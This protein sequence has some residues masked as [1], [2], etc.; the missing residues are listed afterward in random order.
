LIVAVAAPVF[1]GANAPRTAAVRS[2]SVRGGATKKKGHI[3]HVEPIVREAEAKRLLITC[4]TQIKT[5]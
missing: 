1:G 5:E 3:E 4:S 2:I